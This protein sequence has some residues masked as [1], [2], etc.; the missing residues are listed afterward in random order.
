MHEIIHLQKKGCQ[1]YYKLLRGKALSQGH[2]AHFEEKWHAELNRT[3]N[4]DTW[5]SINILTKNIRFHN[6][7]KW[8]QYR[9]VRRV[10]PTNKILCKFVPGTI[11]ACSICGML[12]DTISHTFVHCMPTSSFWSELSILLQNLG[13]TIEI[14]EKSIL[15]GNFKKAAMSFDNLLLLYA[16]KFIWECKLKGSS[17]IILSFKTY[18]LSL[19]LSLKLSFAILNKSEQLDEGWHIFHEHL[20]S[21]HGRGG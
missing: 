16:K 17:P 20:V 2:G 8:L 7:I 15:F 6:N 1:K 18:L 9:L 21:E 19:I 5:D 3:F 13:L 10:L 11:N 14:N 12:N 4:V